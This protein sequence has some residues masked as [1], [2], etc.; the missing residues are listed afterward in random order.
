MEG[1]LKSRGQIRPILECSRWRSKSGETWWT[2]YLTF[3]PLE[4]AARLI[5][6]AAPRLRFT[7]REEV[8][9][10]HGR[11]LPGRSATQLG[12]GSGDATTPNHSRSQTRRE[13]LQ[14]PSPSISLE[15]PQWPSPAFRYKLL[16]GFLTE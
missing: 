12:G 16:Y 2:L 11:Y 13:N 10:I 14:R 4:A 6:D 15:G 5:F 8:V 7:G 9:W 1:S 3:M